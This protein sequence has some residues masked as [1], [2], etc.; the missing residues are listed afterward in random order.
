MGKFK[1]VV[2]I[3]FRGRGAEK[4]KT[5]ARTYLCLVVEAGKSRAKVTPLSNLTMKIWVQ[6]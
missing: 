3:W 4:R 2:R 6:V 5:D 1:V